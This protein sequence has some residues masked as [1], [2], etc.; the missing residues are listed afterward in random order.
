MHMGRTT[1][2]LMTVPGFLKPHHGEL[3]RSDTQAVTFVVGKIYFLAF[4][5]PA[6]E[7]VAK[8]RLS[9]AEGKIAQIWPPVGTL[10]WPLPVMNDT[11]ATAGSVFIFDAFDHWNATH[12]SAAAQDG[13]SAQ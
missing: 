7:F 1:R 9:N 11:D 10:S 4:S 5:C 6:A 8:L 12:F 13:K 3:P 2:P